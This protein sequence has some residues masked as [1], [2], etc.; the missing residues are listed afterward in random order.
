MLSVI[1]VRIGLTTNAKEINL[2][3]IKKKGSN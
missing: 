1:K 2:K 3:N